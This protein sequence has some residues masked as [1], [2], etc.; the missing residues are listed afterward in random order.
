MVKCNKLQRVSR[1]TKDVICMFKLPAKPQD[2]GSE[3]QIYEK[4]TEDL[5]IDLITLSRHQLR[6]RTQHHGCY[7]PDRRVTK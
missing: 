7:S 1:E 5:S 6:I 4:S 3:Q 2:G